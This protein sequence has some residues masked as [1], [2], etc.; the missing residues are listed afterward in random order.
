MKN[1]SKEMLDFKQTMEE[2]VAFLDAHDHMSFATS[3]D[4]LVTV[5]IV[6]Y[7]SDGLN[8]YFI[9]SRHSKKYPQI[10]ANPKV[11]AC[12]DNVQIMGKAEVLGKPLDEKNKDYADIYSRQLPDIFAQYFSIPGMELVRMVPSLFETWVRTPSRQYYEHL[13]VDARKAYVFKELGK[14]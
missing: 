13:D 8:I 14:E 9:T 10:L 2:K 12:I 7:V 3:S 4:D 11:S 5:R 1:E 6:T